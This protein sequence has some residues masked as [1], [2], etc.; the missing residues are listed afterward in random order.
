MFE[1]R[2][3][4]PLAVTFPACG[5]FALESRHAEGFTMDWTEHDF[6]K[7]LYVADGASR[8][9]LENRHLP[10][11]QGSL[12]I[13]PAGINHRLEDESGHPAQIYALCLQPRVLDAFENRK[14]FEQACRR[15]SNALVVRQVRQTLRQLL[16][17]QT[18]ARP[19][20]GAMVT[21]L[22]LELLTLLLRHSQ[23]QEEAE[24]TPATALNSQAR[25]AAYVRE[26]DRTFYKPES[27]EQVAARLG[28][29]RRRFTQLF[30]EATGSSWLPYLRTLRLKH[31]RLL[32]RE[33]DRTIP[34][35]AFECGFEELSTFYRAFK[36]D[37]DTSP[38]QWRDG[39]S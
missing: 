15:V 14:P 27:L 35:V 7:L 16:F 13:V 24:G 1:T 21:A 37:T 10:L 4:R 5:I 19:G 39:N 31:A 23:G 8:L 18:L 2:T 6:L 20:S 11:Q 12:A 25:V 28:L 22:T 26:L 3:Q 30:R 9:V 33:T 38:A 17:E 34:A 36:Q 29:S 32:L